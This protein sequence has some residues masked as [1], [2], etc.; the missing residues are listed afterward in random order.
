MILTIILDF[1]TKYLLFFCWFTAL[2]KMFKPKID[3]KGNIKWCFFA[4][5]I[6]LLIAAYFPEFRFFGKE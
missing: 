2:D 3:W 1:I 4:A 6:F 5:L